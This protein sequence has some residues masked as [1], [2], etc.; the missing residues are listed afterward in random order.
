MG[1]D[2][3]DSNSDTGFNYPYYLFVPDSVTANDPVPV[4]VEST[5][6]PAPTDEFD[7]HLE[8]AS[9]RATNP[10]PTTGSVGRRIAEELTLPFIHP[11]FPRPESDPVDWR[12][13][14][15]A[16]DAETLRI[17]N[18]PLE[19]IDLQLLA[20]VADARSRLSDQGI[21][22]TDRFLLNGFS[23]SATFANRFAALHPERVLSVSAGGMAGGMA[24]LPRR[25]AERPIAGRENVELPYPV[26][27]GNLTEL[28]GD[29]FNLDAFQDVH[30]FIYLGEEDDN[31]PLLYPD[32]WTEPRI[33]GIAV[34]LYGEDVHEERFPYSKSVYQDADA[35]AIFRTYEGTGHHP[36]PAI[37]DVIEFHKRSLAGD[38]IESI[39]TDIGGTAVDV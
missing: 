8:E 22:T 4:L 28:V 12:H 26:G 13:F 5:N 3:I 23:A 33:R 9:R 19:R 29:P 32:A 10:D 2:L 35:S 31:D 15:H 6:M 21:P 25:E 24:I 14:T 7:A 18:S 37:D 20:M 30:Q 16:L 17:E 36:G 39:R 27:T 34:N 1:V 11:V 38:D